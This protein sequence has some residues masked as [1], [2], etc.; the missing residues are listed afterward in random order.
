MKDTILILLALIGLTFSVQ[1]QTRTNIYSNTELLICASANPN[2]NAYVVRVTPGTIQFNRRLY[3]NV[4][5][6]RT[7]GIIDRV[8]LE[9]RRADIREW[10]ASTNTAPKK[11]LANWVMTNTNMVTVLKDATAVDFLSGDDD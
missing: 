9:M 5:I 11:W 1:S 4:E 8:V 10:C 2:W 3:F 7:N 6:W